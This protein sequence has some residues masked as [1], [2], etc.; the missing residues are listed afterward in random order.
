[1]WEYVVM[2]RVRGCGR[3]GNEA[4][5]VVSDN[6]KTAM[7][8]LI[9]SL[10]ALPA[11]AAAKSADQTCSAAKLK[12]TVKAFRCLASESTAELLGKPSD[13]AKCT[14]RLATIFSGT[15]IRA[16]GACPTSGDVDD[17]AALIGG[18]EGELRV[19]LDAASAS[20]DRAKECVAAK[21]KAAGKY[22]LCVAKAAS[23]R[24]R[25]ARE[26]PSPTDGADFRRCHDKLE[27]AF[28]AEDSKG[29]CLTQGDADEIELLVRPAG[30]YLRRANL[31]EANFARTNLAGVDL[32]GA[33]LTYA[34]LDFAELTGAQLSKDIPAAGA[35]AGARSVRGGDD[36]PESA[37]LTGASLDGTIAAGGDLSGVNFNNA[38]LSGA[39]LSGAILV[40]ASM[41][42]ANLTGT[43]F[44]G[45]DLSY[46][47]LVRSNVTGTIFRDANLTF[48]IL[49]EIDFSGS[50][51]DLSGAI[52]SWAS[53]NRTN[54]SHM[55]LAGAVMNNAV[56]VLADL[57]GANLAGA[58][59]FVA[60]LH[61]A[62]MSGADLS[63]ANL[64]GA[65]LNA[66][67]LAGADLSGASIAAATI[68]G[69]NFTDADLSGADFYEPGLAD[70]EAT[71][72]NFT[73][74]NLTGADME[75][76]EARSANLTDA[77]LT[78]A[79][80]TG[81]ELYNANPTGVD[82]STATIDG[83]WATS[84]VACPL[85][86]PAGWLCNLRGLVGPTAVLLFVNVEGADLSGMDMS[87]ALL[88]G[89]AGRAA[90]C[91]IAL[92]SGW[93]CVSNY[94]V[95][96][97]AQLASAD[98]SGADLSGLDLR[99]VSLVGANLNGANLA[100]ADLSLANA[101]SASFA[102]ADLSHAN[103]FRANLSN[104]SF[105]SSD[106]S[107]AELDVANL[108][109]VDLSS[110]TL[111]RAHGENVNGCPAAL[112]AGWGCLLN[113]LIGPTADLSFVWLGYQDLSAF[114][115]SAAELT[116][117]HAIHLVACP[118]ALPAGWACVDNDVVGP[119]ATLI[120]AIL[121]GADLS[122]LDLSDVDFTD[123]N[124]SGADLDS[125]DLT[126]VVW[127]ATR[128]PDDTSSNTNG[129]SPES[130][131]GHLD[132]A[133]VTGGC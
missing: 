127:S 114:D 27:G 17:V 116:G 31:S 5:G 30:L 26:A 122:G 119:T 79:N 57:T 90:A 85:A 132:G 53:A 130:C 43:N 48:A 37:D 83:I 105:A 64:T 89:V 39:D 78:G 60:L 29:G 16:R 19:A 84:L 86:L 65:T 106:L 38:D 7:S 15:E 63:M 95:G 62:Q 47:H 99:E 76:M 14:T 9:A 50:G 59:L 66:A 21:S 133:V 55:D 35:E 97:F 131:G 67:N 41:D 69:A 128:C 40:R 129:S 54:L 82:L 80:L 109:G 1:M 22:A 93:T 11:A 24:F 75:R 8:V 110:A 2:G 32:I 23:K 71:S 100:G 87:A 103:L 28:A 68:G 88:P 13:A 126:G 45:A 44:T 121:A 101:P 120:G 6:L 70:T 49:S 112:P 61:E 34:Y 58:N 108:S 3:T 104:A 72:T 102:N 125:S 77:N 4:R 25:P 98:L 42:S 46:A 111:F 96:Y 33:N 20:G 81:I 56:L 123:A 36:E 107:Y 94:L 113:R 115:L 91:P 10:C 92:P 124:L 18:I 51:A 118:A 52:L 73:R 12:A 74:A 117:V